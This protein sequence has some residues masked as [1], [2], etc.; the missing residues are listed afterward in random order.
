MTSGIVPVVVST[1]QLSERD[2]FDEWRETFALKLARVNAVA[3]HPRQFRCVM[4]AL[5]LG[6][7]S[8][9]HN[10]VAPVALL[11]TRE[12]LRDGDED[13][14]LALSATGTFEAHFNDGSVSVG[15]GSA[16][17]LSHGLVGRVS[18][19]G[20]TTLSLRLPRA[21]LREAVGPA[22]P[23]VL[24]VFRRT[25]PALQ[26]LWIY[27]R[28]LLDDDVGLTAEAA[29][30]AG[31]QISELVVN[32]LD[33]TAALVREER[34]GGLKAARLQAVLRA[35]ERHLTDPELNA[36]RVGATLGLSQRYVHY[37]LAEA[38]TT[39]SQVTRQK[40]LQR[41]RHMLNERTAPPRR[42][43]DIAYSVGFGDL[44]TFNHAFRA[45]FGCT[46]SE[47]RRSGAL[48]RTESP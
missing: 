40:R 19:T 13:L 4:R 2:R 48:T 8:V 35:I 27:A 21:L 28:G 23:P 24:R 14:T 12:L 5:P 32:L 10:D 26:L 29:C 15:P 39:F 1:D 20:G 25:D 6:C 3:P 43:V 42:I 44:S 9:V 11:R 7:L 47:S 16:T 17:L 46:P 22:A 45:Y 33:P 38:G 34:F 18:T 36:G 31:R 41:A 30:L 37:L